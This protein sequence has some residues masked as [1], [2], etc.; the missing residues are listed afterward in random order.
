MRCLKS[1]KRKRIGG[2]C[3][4]L[5]EKSVSPL[6]KKKKEVCSFGSSDKEPIE[7]AIEDEEGE[8]EEVLECCAISSY[9]ALKNYKSYLEVGR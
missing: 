8:E 4:S 6:V 1:G 7:E 3:E 2:S 9:D 5:F